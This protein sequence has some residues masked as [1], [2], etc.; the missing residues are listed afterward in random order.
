MYTGVFGS[1]LC[2]GLYRILFAAVLVSFVSGASPLPW[3]SARL[4]GCCSSF[5]K[6]V[7]EASRRGGW[8]ARHVAAYLADSVDGANDWSKA[9]GRCFDTVCTSMGVY[10]RSCPSFSHRRVQFTNSLA[11]ICGFCTS[12]RLACRVGNVLHKARDFDVLDGGWRWHWFGIEIYFTSVI[13]SYR[14]L[15]VPSRLDC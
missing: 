2:L 6:G 7:A 13:M 11:L 14:Q 15:F 5:S 12:A 3:S 8:A 1:H 4:V 10:T 9:H